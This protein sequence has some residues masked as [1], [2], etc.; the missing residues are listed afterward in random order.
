MKF[1]LFK[2]DK[3]TVNDEL[4]LGLI[5]I[6]FT[7]LGLLLCITRP[8]SQ[9]YSIV[10]GVLMILVGIMLTIGLMYRLFTNDKK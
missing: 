10:F 8:I 3:S 6:C 1:N 5:I 9:S 4:L 2:N 7:A